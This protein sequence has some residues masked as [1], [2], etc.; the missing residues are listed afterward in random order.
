MAHTFF[1]YITATNLED[2]LTSI[3]GAKHEGLEPEVEKVEDG[4]FLEYIRNTVDVYRTLD[5]V[6]WRDVK[7]I[8]FIEID[9]KAIALEDRETPAHGS[10]IINLKGHRV[11][12]SHITDNVYIATVK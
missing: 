4:Y 7:Y 2:L 6:P 3:A 5:Y 1:R 9:I 8:A 12:P 10:A 11:K